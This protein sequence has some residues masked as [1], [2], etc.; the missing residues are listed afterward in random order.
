MS[1][2]HLINWIG[3]LSQKKAI[4]IQSDQN[5][6]DAH[7]SLLLATWPGGAVRMAGKLLERG[8]PPLSWSRIMIMIMT[9]MIMT[10][11]IMTMMIMTMMIMTMVM[12]MMM[13]L[14]FLFCTSFRDSHHLCNCVRL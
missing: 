14:R 2:L 7:R 1:V 3:L 9:M 8:S 4:V 10:M 13:F 11:M 6:Q 12:I 5:D